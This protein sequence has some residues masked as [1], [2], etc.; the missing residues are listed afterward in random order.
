MLTRKNAG[1]SASD[2]TG[3]QLRAIWAGSSSSG[4]W[5]NRAS[6]SARSI[7]RPRRRACPTVARHTAL[8]ILTLLALLLLSF[9]TRAAARLVRANA[10]LSEEIEA[11][12]AAEEALRQSHKME[13]IGQLTGGIAH[14]FNNLLQAIHVGLSS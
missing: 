13:A 5:P 11:R 9:V 4:R 3:R 14:D 12:T 2:L 10:R 8:V 7:Y 6:V 1:A